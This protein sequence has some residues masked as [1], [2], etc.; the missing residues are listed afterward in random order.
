MLPIRLP[1]PALSRRGFLKASAL[2][3]AGLV[4]GLHAPSGRITSAHAAD[5]GPFSSYLSIAPD[6]T[7]TVLSAQFDTG[8]GIHTGIASLVAEELDAAWSQMRVEGVA[9]NTRLYGNVTWGGVMQGTGGSSSVVTSFDRYRRA[10]ATA[11]AMLV[12]AAATRWGVPVSEIVVAEGVVSHPRAGRASFGDLAKD[13]A[14]LPA[15]D[16]VELKPASA[17]RFIGN[18]A[19]RRLDSVAKT[20]GKQ[21]FPL[22]V[23]LPGML[24][25]IIARPPR[26]GA[27]VASFD[28]KA[29]MAV[30][31]VV[32]V[33]Q[34][35]AGVAVVAENT[36]AARQ[37]RE[38][39]KV[40]WNEDK[41]EKRGSEELFADYRR[42]ATEGAANPVRKDGDVAAAFASAA[43]VFEATFEFPYLAHAA[44]EPLDA[45][46]ARTGDRIEV[47]G[48]HQLPDLYQRV[49]A[50]I[51][52]VPPEQVTLHVMMTGGGFG[53][54]GVFDADVIAEVVS[55]AKAI[56]WKAPVKLMWTREDDM[57]GGRYR[58]MYVHAMKAGL[59]ADGRLVA[60]QDRIVGQSIMKGTFLE[61][62][63]VRNGV[64]G[65][66]VEGSSIPYA[67]PNVQIDLV[68][69][70]IGVPVLPWRSVGSTHNAYAM[71]VF[72]DELAAAAGRDP[73]EF[74]LAMLD[75]HP[76]HRGVLERVRDAS[77]WG[78]PLPAG[79][80][81]GVALAESFGSFVA[82]VAEV[83]VIDGAVK[84][85]RVV[86][87][88]DCG[89]AVNPDVI[90]AQMEGA[91]GFGLGAILKGAITLKE[92]T[93][94]QTNF[95][96]Y[97]V[98]RIDEMPS[99]EVH[100][101]PSSERPSGV[102]EPGTPPI[103][104]AVANAVAALTGQRI[105][106]L[107]INRTKL[108]A[109]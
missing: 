42:L 9:G 36:W 56:R 18:E 81:R 66:S 52:G 14:L 12:A 72:I 78:R 8:Q 35:P 24:T 103:G 87:A 96:G 85:D 3:G 97:E 107:P 82:Q 98:L 94:E 5:G 84:V 53:R 102:G 23:R 37:G 46:A 70:E 92:G 51:A 90:K 48:G 109:A 106:T 54:R 61:P 77:N 105:H 50:E 47:W 60:W 63:L 99:V 33:V 15:P 65:T 34:V 25:A 93:V 10:G 71:E 20:T 64:D 31:G 32:E 62:F 43:K 101:V 6:S 68:T 27:T 73:I 11:R 30:K 41:A 17:W 80:G 49:A 1:L 39:L 86:C 4:I 83:R 38:A 44:L 88:V 22:D 57:A 19:L 100:I 7:V 75:A 55:I 21:M 76:R 28:A 67:V 59:S 79:V 16:S 45:V 104:P 26:F 58:P 91:I 74:R 40:T 95:D 29:A 108:G 13:A 89:I 69:T 2:A